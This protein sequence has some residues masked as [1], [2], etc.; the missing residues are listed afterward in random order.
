MTPELA[1]GTGVGISATSTA[2]GV[3]IGQVNEYLQAGA[4]LVA[5]LSGGAAFLYYRAQTR[6]LNE[7]K[8]PPQP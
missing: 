5:M 4:F 2:V 8:D 3:T 7:K 1:A 6:K